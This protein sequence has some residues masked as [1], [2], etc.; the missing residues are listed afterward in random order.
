MEGEILCPRYDG[1]RLLDSNDFAFGHYADESMKFMDEFKWSSNEFK[2]NQ[3]IEI[4]NVHEILSHK[5]L[6]EEILIKYK[7]RI[8]PLMPIV[9]KFFK[10]ITDANF[11]KISDEVSINYIDEFWMLFEKF[12]AFENV[13]DSVFGEYINKPLTTLYYILKRKQ[14]VDYYDEVLADCLRVSDQTAEIIIHHFMEKNQYSEKSYLPKSLKASEFEGILMKYVHSI[15]PAL[16]LL[17]VLEMYQS[18]SVCP[19]SDK[20]RLEARKRQKSMITDGSVTVINSHMGVGVSFRDVSE[21]VSVEN[22]PE[23]LLFIYDRQWIK[24]NLDF[25][26]LLNNFIY[27]FGFVDKEF[28]SVFPAVSSR[29]GVFERTLGVKGIKEYQTGNY[30]NLYS[31]KTSVDM[32]GYIE[33]LKRNNI[34]LESIIKWFFEVYLVEE[35]N[36]EGFSFSMSSNDSSYLE[37]CRNL[38]S[39]MDGVLKQYRLYV[40]DGVIDRELLEMSSRPVEF[41]TLPSLRRDKYAYENNEE[42]KLEMYYLFSDQCLLAYIPRIGEKYSSFYKLLQNEE[43]YLDDY[44]HINEANQI[45]WL[46]NRKA[47][48]IEDNIIKLNH[49]RVFVLNDLYS[50]EVICRDYYPAELKGTLD[51]MCAANDLVYTSSLF[52]Y[53]ETD[54]MNYILNKSQYSNGLDL[55]NRYIHST[56]SDNEEMHERDYI[57]LMKIMVLVV[58]KINEEFCNKV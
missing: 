33:E 57:E 38:A 24:Q 19:V 20:L 12:K 41:E 26:T 58:I 40:E 4:Y 28:R 43:V 47:I 50:H 5:V 56:Y 54:Y 46:S 34:Q 21:L 44:K 13:S 42:I 32:H 27:I 49:S 6:K 23:G 8:K 55:R 37:R 1:I 35:F 25:A 10:C 9:A 14:I 39:E 18:A 22:T 15:H 45:K 31:M 2:V 17:K 51:A 29:L 7:T 3:V 16:G 52:S 30:Y 36:A 53:P 11:I 48:E